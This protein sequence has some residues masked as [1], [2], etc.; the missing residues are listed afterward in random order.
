MM[1]QINRQ[2]QMIALGYGYGNNVESPN[3]KSLTTEDIQH[4]DFDKVDLSE[5]IGILIQTDNMPNSS[6]VSIESLTGKDSPLNFSTEKE[7]Q[8]LNIDEQTKKRLEGIQTDVISRDAYEQQWSIHQ[9][10]D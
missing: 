9:P 5:W 4:V 6:K 8:R 1:E 2:P 3:C 10:N 7:K